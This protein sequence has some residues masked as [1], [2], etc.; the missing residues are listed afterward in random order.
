M[1]EKTRGAMMAK[2]S[3]VI[4]TDV[5]QVIG[6]LEEFDLSVLQEALL[7]FGFTIA[8]RPGF[9]VRTSWGEVQF[10]ADCWSRSAA[11]NGCIT[12]TAQ[13]PPTTAGE[14]QVSLIAADGRQIDLLYSPGA[15]V[16]ICGDA[17]HLPPA[18]RRFV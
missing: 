3:Q 11:M 17:V 9:T 7:Q 16:I 10:E 2:R 14:C 15:E 18:N 1:T 12:Y 13:R 6:I 5:S 8:R 4:K